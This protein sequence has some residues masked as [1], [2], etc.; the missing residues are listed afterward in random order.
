MIA[1]ISQGVALGLQVFSA[2]HGTI[3]GI[4]P[5]TGLAITPAG[6][7]PVTDLG[8]VTISGPGGSSTVEASSFFTG[9][10]LLVIG[11]LGLLA[12]ILFTGARR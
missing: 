12:V 11:G 6:Q 1:G 7:V 4:D 8:A 10:N 5:A 2:I 3:T 9:T